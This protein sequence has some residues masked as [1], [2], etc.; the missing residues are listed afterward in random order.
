MPQV[1]VKVESPD[2]VLKRN[3]Y[4]DAALARIAHVNEAIRLVKVDVAAVGPLPASVA[5][6]GATIA[7]LKAEVEIRLDNIEEKL[8]ALIAAL[9]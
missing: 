3:P 5:L 4:A 8:N 2:P 9:S 6:T 7:T 1:K